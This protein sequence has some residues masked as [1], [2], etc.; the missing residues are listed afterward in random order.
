MATWS[1][2]AP[3]ALAIVVVAAIVGGAG[4]AAECSENADCNDGQ[5]CIEGLC[6]AIPASARIILPT[7]E[8]VG[9]RF[10]LGVEIAFQGGE[11]TVTVSP[12]AGAAGDPCVPFPEVTR[13]VRGDSSQFS[14]YL[15]TVSNLPALGPSFSITVRVDVNGKSIFSRIDLS[16][17]ETP[18]SG[19]R[20]TAPFGGD[21][22]VRDA[23]ITEVALA[24]IVADA[25]AYAEP[26]DDVGAPI[27]QSTPRVSLAAANGEMKAQVPA[28]RGPYIVWVE[29]FRDG[30]NHR[31]GRAMRGGP[32]EYEAR[33]VEV[34]LM[35]R[36]LDG[37]DHLVE[38]V[39]RVTT[40]GDD[41]FC[42]S[43]QAPP[44]DGPVRC[45]DRIQTLAGVDGTDLVVVSLDDD[46]IIDIAALP[47]LVSGPVAVSIRVSQG[48]GHA[49]FF[50]PVVIQSQQG[51]SWL[52][53]QL[54]IQ[55]GE[56]VS[57]VASAA[58]PQ[59]GFPW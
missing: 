20:M 35:S 26:T 31:C 28:L 29:S 12:T 51:E 45:R 15:V 14:Q 1:P 23:P 16:G 27:G 6:G 41:V 5:S 49:A 10:D 17:P 56:M 43:R 24:D 39:I 34:M 21:V 8:N 40:G 18:A 44:R 4:C 25:V 57:V 38:G 47:R 59:P 2:P 36:S 53:G 37:D 42:D 50:G 22:H 52:A 58:P 9:E 54:V 55:D 30:V 48:N 11:A 19:I 3:L 32:D 33:D 7:N 13:R 46:G